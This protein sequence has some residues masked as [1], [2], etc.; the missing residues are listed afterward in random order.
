M[1]VGMFQGTRIAQTKTEESPR[2]RSLP[3]NWNTATANGQ[4]KGFI[5]WGL[6]MRSNVRGYQRGQTEHWR[7]PRP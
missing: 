4:N 5:P 1:G 6:E 2:R 7:R 3:N